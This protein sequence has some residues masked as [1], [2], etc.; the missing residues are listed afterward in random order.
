ME[1][2]GP[3]STLLLAMI[4]RSE[5]AMKEK[6]AEQNE[7]LAEQAA[8][9]ER[10]KAIKTMT[11]GARDGGE[12]SGRSRQEGALLRYAHAE[13]LIIKAIKADSTL[14]RPQLFD[15]VKD[16][17]K[18]ETSGLKPYGRTRIFNIIKRLVQDK[19]ILPP[20]LKK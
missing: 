1:L 10:L 19:K 8:E 16:K 12:E 15:Q 5:A 2:N 11:E 18:W 13:N 20:P 6:L 9:I 17:K 14:T 4:A 7:K 3:P